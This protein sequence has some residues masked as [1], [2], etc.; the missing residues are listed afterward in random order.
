MEKR[1]DT[2]SLPVGWIL[3]ENFVNFFVVF[4][5]EVEGCGVVIIVGR[6]VGKI[7][8]RKF[9]SFSEEKAGG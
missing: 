9:E 5:S 1:N 7:P 2:G 6:S 3:V 8:S 4:L